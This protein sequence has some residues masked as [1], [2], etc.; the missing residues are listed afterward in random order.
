MKTL[1]KLTGTTD[2]ATNIMAL[3]GLLIV[4]SLMTSFMILAIMNGIKEF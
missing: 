3:T 2:I 4:T 1:T